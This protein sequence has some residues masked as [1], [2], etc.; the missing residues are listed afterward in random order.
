MAEILGIIGLSI[1]VANTTAT[2]SRALFDVVETFIHTR[3]E[4]AD[5]AQH[6]QHL[7]GTLYLLSDQIST[8]ENLF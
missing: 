7:L 3:E 4:I 2:L 8:C 1:A 5:I 6:L